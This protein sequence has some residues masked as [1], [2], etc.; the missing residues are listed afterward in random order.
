ML[1]KLLSLMLMY[2]VSVSYYFSIVAVLACLWSSEICDNS[3]FQICGLLCICIV[4]WGMYYKNPMK[5]R[6]L[7]ILISLLNSTFL[8][9]CDMLL[10]LK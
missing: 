9:F 1:E 7:Q 10:L 4:S 8:E 5:K 2:V 3:K 6:H